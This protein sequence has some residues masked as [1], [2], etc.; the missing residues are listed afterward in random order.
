MTNEIGRTFGKRYKCFLDYLYFDGAQLRE[1]GT[2]PVCGGEVEEICEKDHS[3]LCN[4]DV[5]QGIFYCGLCGKPVCPCGSHDVIGLSRITGYY[6]EIL[7]WN[8]GKMMELRQR[9]RYNINWWENPN[10]YKLR[11]RILFCARVMR[12]MVVSPT[13]MSDTICSFPFTTFHLLLLRTRRQRPKWQQKQNLFRK[14][15]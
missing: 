6:A 15:G 7:G 2:C 14:E 8:E 13:T 10:L 4:R 12:W 1:N 3:C 5:H 11:A 9:T